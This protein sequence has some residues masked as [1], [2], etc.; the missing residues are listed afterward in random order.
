MRYKILLVEDDRYIAGNLKQRL[1]KFGSV[2][3]ANAPDQAR[4]I[5]ENT[6][7]DFSL[8]DLNLGLTDTDGIGLLP[9]V[10]QKGIYPVILTSQESQDKKLLSFQNGCKKFFVKH[11]FM[12]SPDKYLNP[13]IESLDEAPLDDFFKEKFLTKD[14][15]L[16]SSIKKLHKVVKSGSHNVL[17]TGETGVGKT[18]IAKMIHSISGRKGK[19]VHL[20]IAEIKEELLESELFGHK[21]GSFTGAIADRKG[22]FEEADEG[23]LFLDEIDSLPK[24]LQVKIQV[25][26]EERSFARL[27]ESHKRGVNF[28]LITATCQD[29]SGLIQEGKFRQDFYFRLSGYELKIPSLRER[30]LDI[31][32]FLDTTIQSFTSEVVFEK[33]ALDLL[34]TFDWPGNVRQLMDTIRKFEVHGLYHIMEE[35]VVEMLQIKNESK[36][37]ELLSKR[38]KEFIYKNGFNE[39]MQLIEMEMMKDAVKKFGSKTTATQKLGIGNR[40]G[41]RIYQEAFR[42]G[43]L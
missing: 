8:I 39:F 41:S 13:I 29:L 19:F 11:K 25:A 28:N 10:I 14:E 1:S 43:A 16:K 20:N 37:T 23:T 26:L 38:H 21:K 9:V 6:H 3:V 17:L 4:A 24:H 42:A 18:T 36:S 15:E 40:K 5:L 30:P 34:L 32:Y 31:Q 33:K 2:V 12:D 27:G 35:D 22:Y 7:F